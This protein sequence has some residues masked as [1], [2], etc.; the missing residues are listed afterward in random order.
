MFMIEIHLAKE[1]ILLLSK[2]RRDLADQG[3][4]DILVSDVDEVLKIL[5]E[6]KLKEVP[7]WKLWL[8]GISDKKQ[9]GKK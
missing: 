8:L 6:T 4:H 5:Y 2:V 1:I 9:G 3:G 7:R